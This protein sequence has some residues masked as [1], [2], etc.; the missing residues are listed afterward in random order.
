M[1]VAG[2]VR[3][4]HDLQLLLGKRLQ[5][6]PY[7][8]ALRVA[9]GLCEGLARLGCRRGRLDLLLRPA[10]ARERAELVYGPVVHYREEPVAHAASLH[11][12]APRCS[13]DLQEG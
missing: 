12:V 1:G 11:P 8:L 13:P 3:Q 6:F 7:L 4:L 5:G 2:E 10:A 9:P